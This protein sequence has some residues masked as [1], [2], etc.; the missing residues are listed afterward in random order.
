MVKWAP[1]A[2][3]FQGKAYVTITVSLAVVSIETSTKHHAEI[4]DIGIFECPYHVLVYFRH[5]HGHGSVHGHG[6]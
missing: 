6:I 5:G 3:L 2:N 4:S 1:A